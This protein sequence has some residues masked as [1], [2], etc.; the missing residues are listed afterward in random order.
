[1]MTT[2]RLG[3]LV[4]VV[5]RC[6]ERTPKRHGKPRLKDLLAC[7][8][9]R[10]ARATV[11][12]NWRHALP[13]IL[14]DGFSM[15]PR[16]LGDTPH[17]CLIEDDAALCEVLA[18]GLSAADYRV[19][20][21]RRGSQAEEVLRE[22]D[23]DLAIIDIGL[24]DMSGIELIQGLR[25]SGSRLPVLVLTARGST[26]DRVTGLDAGADD[27]LTKPF[28]L[29]ELLARLRAL[30]RRSVG[31]TATRLTWG[32][33][34]LDLA[35]RAL[36]VGGQPMTLSRREYEVLRLLMENA[37]RVVT[38]DRLESELY[39]WL[40]PVASNA[41]EV[42]VHHLRKKLGPDT[43]RTMRGVGYMFVTPEPPRR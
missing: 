34:Q 15:E 4:A 5:R 33:I 30:L 9:A 8:T 24:P 31:E 17:L 25:R 35:A 19:H 6:Q 1:M 20:Q 26:E 16:P 11:H 41:V 39:G 37:G 18:E 12:A 2:S 13:D 21:V 10:V 27:Y 28:D 38:R 36:T 3:D 32:D 43:I 7:R 42:H 29:E 14:G 22:S 40:D 23:F